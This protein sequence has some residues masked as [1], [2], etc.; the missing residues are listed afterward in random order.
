[1][2]NEEGAAVT[3]DVAV[4]DVSEFVSEEFGTI[5][6]IVIDLEPWFVGKDVAD[7]LGYSNSRKALADHV[8]E[9]D[10]NTVTIRYGIQENPDQTVS[11]DE[12]TVTN[13][14]G[15]RGN[16]N[17]TIINEAGLYSLI[18]SSKLP[19][20]K[21]FKHWVT[22]EVLPSIRKRGLYV[23]DELLADD[24]R[25]DS[26]LEEL[27][28]EKAELQEKLDEAAERYNGLLEAATKEIQREEREYS[29]LLRQNKVL[30]RKLADLRQTIQE[31]SDP[32]FDDYYRTV[33]MRG[34]S[35][36]ISTIAADYGLSA[37][38]LNRWLASEGVQIKENGMWHLTDAYEGNGYTQTVTKACRDDS[39][40]QMEE[41][42]FMSW[43]RKGN[44]FIR[45]LLAK[46]GYYPE[47]Y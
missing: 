7:A 1:M 5:R 2:S 27:R 44:I 36:L 23:T 33:E 3:E 14:D 22:R 25:L 19:A 39:T 45:E 10:K 15:I 46:I 16:P 40:G 41:T 12:N 29:R 28:Q 47:D 11:E 30:E 13:Y 37:V 4:K 31:S 21:E 18:F 42:T 20:A 9:E 35:I 38:E 43:T 8:D 17:R 6:T 26:A 32:A 34:D 24:G